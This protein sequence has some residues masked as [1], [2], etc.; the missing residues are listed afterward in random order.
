MQP[1][2]RFVNG[3][4]YSGFTTMQL[5]FAELSLWKSGIEIAAWPS[6][7]VQPAA[8]VDQDA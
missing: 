5:F 2:C 8:G 3:K 4:A 6:Q 7:P 1:A